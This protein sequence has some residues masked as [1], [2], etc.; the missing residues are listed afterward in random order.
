VGFELASA[1][2]AQDVDFV[3]DLQS[4]DGSLPHAFE[5]GVAGVWAW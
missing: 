1:H 4:A 3:A 5:F 2:A